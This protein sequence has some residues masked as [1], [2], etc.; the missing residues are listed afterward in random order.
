M[1]TRSLSPLEAKLILHLE[2]NKQGVVT[3]QDTMAILNITYDHARQVLHRLARD[4]WLALIQPGKY[5]L[6]PAERGEVAFQDMNPL[7][8]GRSLVE[9]Y[10]FTFATA[11]FFHGLSTQA[12]LIVFLAS[13][14]G[15]PRRMLV[16]EKE[17]RLVI[18]PPHKF[19]GWTETNAYGSQVN[20]AEAEKTILDSLDKPG[21][22]GDVPEIAMM[23]N[24][25]SAKLDWNKLADYA[26]RFR[27][28][29]LLQ[30]LGYLVDLLKLPV[31]D[32]ARNRLLEG[33]GENTKCYLGQP[34][35]WS[36]GGVYN[37]TWRVVDNIPRQELLAEVEAR[38]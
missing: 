16:R 4:R 11:A 7:F 9:P 10:Y 22:A 1:T 6:I 12:S 32:T 31:N 36:Q 25:G 3:T 33:S 38:G 17:Y 8:I 5:E 34:R 14:Q 24:R 30:R 23:L 37:S 15:R 21:Y 26:V 2:W 28:K 19:F 27:S 13:T 35:R 29:A 20:M 18:Q